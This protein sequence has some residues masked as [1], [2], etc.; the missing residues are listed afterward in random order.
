MGLEAVEALARLVANLAAPLLLTELDGTTH[1]VTGWAD[2]DVADLAALAAAQHPGL[3][4]PVTRTSA[5]PGFVVVVDGTAV[6]AEPAAVLSAQA[7]LLAG[8]ATPPEAML[9]WLEPEQPG[10]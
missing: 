3:A 9:F 10:P 8:D 2:A 6:L 7:V 4:L 1:Q 5:G